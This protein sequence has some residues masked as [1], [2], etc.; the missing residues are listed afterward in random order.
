MECIAG[1]YLGS[2]KSVEDCGQVQLPKTH[3]PDPSL[4]REGRPAERREAPGQ[5]EWRSLCRRSSGPK[6]RRTSSCRKVTFEQVLQRT[7]CESFA[8]GVL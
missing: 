8:Q 4:G 3:N 2:N 5:R 7:P 6:W 1:I